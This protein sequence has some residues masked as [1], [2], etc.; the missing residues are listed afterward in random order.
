MPSQQLQQQPSSATTAAANAAT[1]AT[2][3]SAR[4]AQ[5]N[6]ELANATK[7]WRESSDAAVAQALEE[8]RRAEVRATELEDKLRRVEVE[9]AALQSDV[10]VLGMQMG[11]LEAAGEEQRGELRRERATAAAAAAAL[12]AAKRDKAAAVEERE[13]TIEAQAGMLQQLS[14]ELERAERCREDAERSKTSREDKASKLQ[15]E[16]DRCAK[17]LAQ[18][19]HQLHQL[20]SNGGHNDI[21]GRESLGGSSRASM[22][23]V[24]GGSSSM[25]GYYESEEVRAAESVARQ[26]QERLLELVAA[27]QA[28][29]RDAADARAAS[30][31]WESEV[32]ERRAELELMQEEL[33]GCLEEERGERRRAE[34][35]CC[36]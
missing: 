8:K 23:S 30:N 35:W 1:T 18:R 28:A 14:S 17:E 7:T 10:A 29:E 11:A 26:S 25:G 2:A 15:L 20:H 32:G 6:A 3:T 27:K 13:F 33:E 36:W 12:E 34:V 4:E 22:G 24:H 21:M 5:D 16:L 9:R 19:Q 31:K